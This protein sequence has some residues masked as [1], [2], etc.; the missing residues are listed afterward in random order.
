MYVPNLSTAMERPVQYLQYPKTPKNIANNEKRWT[1]I[2]ILVLLETKTSQ[3][4]TD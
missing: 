3:D 4:Y 1:T 2:Y